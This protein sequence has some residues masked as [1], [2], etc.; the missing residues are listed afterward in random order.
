ML[1]FTL[2]KIAEGALER[3]VNKHILPA[4]T[5]LCAPSEAAWA[6]Q[7]PLCSNTWRLSLCKPRGG[8]SK[9]NQTGWQG[10]TVYHVADAKFLMQEHTLWSC[11]LVSLKNATM[12]KK[13][14][15]QVSCKRP[16]S[17]HFCILWEVKVHCYGNL[18]QQASQGHP[19]IWLV[20]WMCHQHASIDVMEW[21][22][23]F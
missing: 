21:R 2:Q 15:A 20:K 9:S 22:M 17:A 10:C 16:S 4:C 13:A 7:V 14:A 8:C 3:L 19:Q 1:Y 23:H 18:E 5:V 12:S 11:E 6:S